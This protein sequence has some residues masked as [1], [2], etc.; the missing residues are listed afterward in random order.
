MGIFS[1]MHGVVLT[2]NRLCV[3]GSYFGSMA[4]TLHYRRALHVARAVHDRLQCRLT[5]YVFR[6]V[7]NIYLCCYH[8]FKTPLHWCQISAQLFAGLTLT[9]WLVLFVNFVLIYRI[10]RS[11][12]VKFA[13]AI[14]IFMN[15]TG[16][17]LDLWLFPIIYSFWFLSNTCY[18]EIKIS[19]NIILNVSIVLNNCFVR[20]QQNGL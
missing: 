11:S 3:R 1:R 14:Y 16:H 7:F 15:T 2:L 20:P 4:S 8:Y 18:F 5:D 10:V 13:L 9:H 17:V 6:S 19:F 12:N